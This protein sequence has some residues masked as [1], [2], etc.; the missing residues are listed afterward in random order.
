MNHL[1]RAWARPIVRMALIDE[2]RRDR[3]VVV[4][5]ADILV[6]EEKMFCLQYQAFFSVQM[7]L[8]ICNVSVQAYDLVQGA[9][10]SHIDFILLLVKDLHSTLYSVARFIVM[11]NACISNVF[12]S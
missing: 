4:K 3:G 6:R 1:R 12:L 2:R 8:L 9:N 5:P 7:Y 11:L 10:V